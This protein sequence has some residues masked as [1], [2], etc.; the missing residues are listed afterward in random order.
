MSSNSIRDNFKNENIF[1]ENLNEGTEVASTDAKTFL[2]SKGEIPK[3]AKLQASEAKWENLES[4]DSYEDNFLDN[5]KPT[6]DL[7]RDIYVNSIL[8]NS[9]APINPDAV[10]FSPVE[11]NVPYTSQQDVD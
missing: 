7:S 8:A 11:L 4:F 6:Y 2:D 1:P 9:G 3:R 5:Y 10:V